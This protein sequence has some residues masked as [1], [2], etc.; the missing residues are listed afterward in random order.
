MEEVIAVF[1]PLKTPGW[2]LFLSL[3]GAVATGTGV[4]LQL[5][6]KTLDRNRRMVLSMLLFFGFLIALFTGAG[7]LVNATRFKKVTVYTSGISIG[8]N[9]I[10]FHKMRGYLIREDRSRSWVNPDAVKKTV[11]SLVVEEKNGKTHLLPEEYYDL[12][13]LIATLDSAYAAWKK[14]D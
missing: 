12:P 7:I 13:R 8:K 2:P 10:P 1:E 5:R 14:P 6:N 3:A 4:W 11:R 9:E